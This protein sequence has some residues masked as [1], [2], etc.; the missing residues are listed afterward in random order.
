M[1]NERSQRNIWILKS[2]A[3]KGKQKAHKQFL[4]FGM[5]IENLIKKDLE[6]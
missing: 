2:L 1:K 3:D 6:K 4:S 5:Y